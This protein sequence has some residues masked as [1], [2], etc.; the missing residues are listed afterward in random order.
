MNAVSPG[1]IKTPM[2]APETHEFLAALH[3]VGRMGEIQRH[4]R[5]RAVPGKRALRHRRDP[6]RRWRPERRPLMRAQFASK[7]NE[8]AHRHHPGHP[9]RHRHPA[10]DSVTPREG[11]PDQGRQP[12]AARRAQEA[13][14]STFVVIEEV[15]T[16][17]WGWGGLPVLEYRK[18]RAALRRNELPIK[19]GFRATMSLLSPLR[20]RAASKIPARACCRRVRPPART[21]RA[22]PRSGRACAGGR[23][24]RWQQMIGLQRRLVRQAVHDRERRCRALGHADRDRAVEFDDGRAHQRASSA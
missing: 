10:A 19:S 1:V 16:D 4:R 17:N 14:E 12:A 3:P 11:G 20:R 9:R 13:A 6:A 21:R 22:L 7:D 5:R 18:K 8:H 23:R 2:H 24:E 15:D